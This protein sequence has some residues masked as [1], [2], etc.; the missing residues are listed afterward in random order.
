MSKCCAH[1]SRWFANHKLMLSVQ[2][3]VYKQCEGHR[4]PSDIH[5]RHT[6]HH[7]NDNPSSD[8]D[9]L[10]GYAWLELQKRETITYFTYFTSPPVQ[11]RG[12]STKSYETNFY[13]IPSSL[14]SR[15]RTI[16]R[17][18]HLRA[19]FWSGRL[20]QNNTKEVDLA[21]YWLRGGSSRFELTR[22]FPKTSQV[23]NPSQVYVL[24]YLRK[25]FSLYQIL[26]RLPVF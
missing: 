19:S 4:C 17:W 23:D 26:L 2:E 20:P 11:P 8:W 18:P 14:A 12:V 1:T 5:V 22:T 21:N 3:P 13:I 25:L 24:R 7:S 16:R 15:I 10:R 9:S 6:L